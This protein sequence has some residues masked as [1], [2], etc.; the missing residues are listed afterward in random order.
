MITIL[1]ANVHY[2]WLSR[3]HLKL[4]AVFSL[5]FNA[6]VTISDLG[7]LQHMAEDSLSLKKGESVTTE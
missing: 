7:K 5:D 3:S 1:P 4:F 6:P 2:L